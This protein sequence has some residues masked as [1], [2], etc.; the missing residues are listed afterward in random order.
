M[1]VAAIVPNHKAQ[2]IDNSDAED[3]KL[4]SCKAT[5]YDIAA[6]RDIGGPSLDRRGAE[7]LD[8]GQTQHAFE[9]SESAP[10]TPT[11]VARR[12]EGRRIP[13]RARSLV[14][15]SL[16]NSKCIYTIGAKNR[17]WREEC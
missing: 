10:A 11:E 17:T 6:S 3:K 9:I 1:L 4:L 14:A 15:R 7:D 8:T 5:S 12:G 2:K 16:Q 13:E